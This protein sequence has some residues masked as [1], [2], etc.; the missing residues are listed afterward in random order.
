MLVLVQLKLQNAGKVRELISGAGLEN[1][2]TA[3]NNQ[4]CQ[5]LDS[6]F[7]N[8]ILFIEVWCNGSTKDFGSFSSGSNPDT[9]TNITIVGSV[10]IFS[11][12]YNVCGKVD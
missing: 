4:S 6:P 5:L 2:V 9:S 7:F 3:I 10:F 1:N 12:R 8:I 11:I